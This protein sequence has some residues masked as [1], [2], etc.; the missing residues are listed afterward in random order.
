VVRIVTLIFSLLVTFH[1]AATTKVTA[2]IDK[3]PA[4][5][6]ESV[7]LTVVADDDVDADALD[8]SVLLKHFIVGRTQVS[9][10]TSSIN[11]KTTR[12]TT[13][14]TLLVPK[15]AGK[16]HIPALSVDGKFTT[17]IA[18]IVLEQGDP[19]AKSQQDIFITSEVSNEQVFV[20]Q[21]FTLTMKLHFAV[22]LK[23]AN[24]TLPVMEGAEIA[25]MGE[26]KTTDDIINGRRFRVIERTFAVT[27]QQSGN[28][29]LAS[30]TLNGEVLVQSNSNRGF[31]NFGETKPISVTGDDFQI[32]VKPKPE[33]FSSHW[34]PSELLSLH[35]EWQ[36]QKM[37][38]TVGDPITRTITL[39]AAAVSVEQ[40]PELTITLPKGLKVYPDQPESHSGVKSGRLISQLKRN[41]AI[42]ATQPGNYDIPAI[43]IP[44]WNTVTN[45]VEIAILPP[46]S[47]TV[48]ASQLTSSGSNMQQE[49]SNSIPTE[50]TAPKTPVEVIVEKHSW[51]TWLFLV[52][53]LT[54][55]LTWFVSARRSKTPKSETA[56]LSNDKSVHLALMA[57]CK[58]ND[59]Q[60]V[61]KL[62]IP[63]AK[64]QRPNGS[65]I[66][67]IDHVKV[68]LDNDEFN[69][70]IDELYQRYYGVSSTEQSSWQGGKL[71][72]AIQEIH[73]GKNT[74]QSSTLSINP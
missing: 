29:T 32:N 7:V 6:K 68:S 43:E 27:P 73:N 4:V 36:P 18:L 37:E 47:I 65:A 44:W 66:H 2:S 39:T 70:A 23:R 49:I 56:Q 20:Q 61:I 31:F 52:L 10:Q 1:V 11:F 60:Q 45:R 50:H 28:L 19:N 30:P 34:L 5:V 17:P 53:W 38:F 42:V 13:W 24:L 3:N 59:G 35:D 62:L 67:T 12:T 14:T 71:L 46:I 54:T 33:N 9:R 58:N 40:L 41:F 51:L 21:M 63:W 48:K 22:E 16:I 69:Q 55:L 26:D 15:K 25:Q 74:K 8:T 57:A 64:Q 72:K